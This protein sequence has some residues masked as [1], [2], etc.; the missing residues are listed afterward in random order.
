LT[1]HNIAV[2]TVV[3]T[4]L[5]AVTVSAILLFSVFLCGLC[6]LWYLV[7]PHAV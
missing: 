1:N 6:Q 7:F 2:V 3:H 5:D 4:H